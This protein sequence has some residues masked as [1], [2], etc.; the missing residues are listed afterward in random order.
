M[1][2]NKLL[3]MLALGACVSAGA[4]ETIAYWPFG[5]WGYADASGNGLDLRANG[6]VSLANGAVAFGGAAG[7]CRTRQPLDLR[8][9]AKGFTVE[10]WVRRP[11][12]AQSTEQMLIEQ[13]RQSSA[14]SAT[15]AFYIVL[16]EE[17]GP[18]VYSMMKTRDG[19]HIDH[20]ANSLGDGKWHHVAF[21]WDPSAAGDDRGRLYLDG[22]RQPQF[23]AHRRTDV[24]GFVRDVL[25]LGSRAGEKCL[26]RGELDDVRITAEPLAPAAFLKARSEENGPLRAEARCDDRTP[27]T[28]ARPPERQEL[29]PLPAGAITARGWIRTML[30]RSR[31][32]MGGHYGEFDPN[33]FELPGLTK[34][35]DARLPGAGWKD[36]PGWCAEMSGE[37]RLGQFELAE[38]LGDAGLQAK[39]RAWRDALLAGQEA[40]GYLGA[41]RPKDNRREDYNA[42]GAHFYYR[43]LL[44]D[45]SRT[46][47]PRLLDALHRGLLWFVREWGGDRKTTYAGPTIIWPMIEVYKLTGDAR[48]LAFC[49]DYAHYLDAHAEWNPHRAGGINATGGFA[50]LSLER[51]AYH[52]VAYAVRAQLAGILSLANDDGNL[53]KASIAS[54]EDHYSNVGWQATYAPV[55]D[56]EHTSFPSCIG[57]TEYC[58]FLCWMEYLQWLA[59]LTGE[60]KYGDLIERMAFN[61]AMGARKK[62][63]RA[64]AYNTSPN[65]FR[66]TKTSARAGC[67]KY[68]EVYCPC[69]FAACCTAQSIRLFPSYLMK[70][71]MRTRGG[72]LTV[73]TYGPCHVEDGG[74]SIEMETSYPFEETVR[75]HVTAKDGWKGALRLRRPVWATDCVVTRNGAACAV[76]AKDG[77]F[78]LEGPWSR[79]EVVLTFG[80][81]PVVR[82][83]RERGMEEPL[84]AIEWGPLVFAQPFKETW[85]PV[86]D[87]P[88]SRPLPPEWPWY[89]VTC[90]EKPTLYAL[91]V[92]TAFDPSSIRVKRV[93]TDAYPW[94]TPPVRLIVPMVRAPQAYAA[95]PERQEKNT[96]PVANPVA[97]GRDAA[98]EDVELVP[99]GATCLRLACFPLAN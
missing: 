36:I 14:L 86:K 73:A 23:A 59:R 41:Y 71:V 72:D 61:A 88:K 94:E 91:P 95:E 57:E 51:G 55:S 99:F 8:T 50:H 66:A 48:L 53:L 12:G 58:N 30:E 27:R 13:T 74:V 40:D 97:V 34:D 70:S 77:W 32:G 69:E 1:R 80:R 31:E 96:A 64:I 63:E 89:D 85:T 46:R 18:G 98:R 24:P 76:T 22:A 83:V 65:Q 62:D 81:R 60:A 26:F 11:A 10:L 37:Y 52:V 21:V 54:F 49:E 19:A 15:G 45:Y 75:L 28:G 44:L 68:Y 35:Y 2:M 56:M 39:F 20:A 84:R 38:T 43:A 5:S 9:C 7:A 87:D 3:M 4:A 25:W 78:A 90:A 33:Q 82:A 92:K 17:F 79:D 47:N 93:A 16:D 29:L 6:D 67:C 42:W